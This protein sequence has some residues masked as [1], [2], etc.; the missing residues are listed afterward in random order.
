MRCR[1]TRALAGRGLASKEASWAST[2]SLFTFFRRRHSRAD[3]LFFSNRFKRLDSIAAWCG[4]TRSFQW[5]RLLDG[6]SS[7]YFIH[8]VSHASYTWF[9]A[10]AR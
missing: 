7:S 2:L 9:P 8:R 5:G 4:V 6:T 10:E 1:M 3:S